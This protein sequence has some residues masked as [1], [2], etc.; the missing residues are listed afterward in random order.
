V[1]YAG[2]NAQMFPALL[3]TSLLGGMTVLG[4]FA[5][6]SMSGLSLFQL[7]QNFVSLVGMPI[8]VPLV[9]GLFFR[10]TPPWS[11]WSTVLVCLLTS[12]V[13]GNLTTF[14]GPNAYQHILGFASPLRPSEQP[15]MV[16]ALGAIANAII[17]SLWF[18]G[19]AVWYKRQSPEYRARVEAFF[20]TMRTP[21]DFGA[22]QGQSNDGAQYRTLGWLCLAYGGFVSLLAIIPNG[23]LGRVCF[24]L[25]GAIIGG[26]G[27]RLLLIARKTRLLAAGAGAPSQ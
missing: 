7:M 27:L 9:W 12:L 17:G 24:I 11:G 3:D 6:Y 21:V 15:T 8:A 18:F 13:I 4:A 10:R 23:M 20:A 5:F 2:C 25:I 1:V 19:T 22:E 26:V 16:F 14:F